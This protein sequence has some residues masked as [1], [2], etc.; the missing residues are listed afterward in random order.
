[1]DEGLARISME[2]LDNI[3][4]LLGDNLKKTIRPGSKLKIAASTF[5]IYAYEA[6]KQEQVKHVYFIA[7]TK[8]SM[9]S[10]DLRRIEEC[11]ID[12]ARKFFAKIDTEQVKYDAVASYGQLM[13][14]V[15]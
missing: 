5:S 15:K 4:Q 6:L 7:E 1:M 13:E 9:S 3:N 14:L 10:M 8:G 12:F 2:I 11:K